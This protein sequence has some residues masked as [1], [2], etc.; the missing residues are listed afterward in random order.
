VHGSKTGVTTAGGED[1]RAGAG[2]KFFETAEDV[3]SDSSVVA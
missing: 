1:V 3:V 2:R